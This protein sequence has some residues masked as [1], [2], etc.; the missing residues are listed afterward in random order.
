[1]SFIW[2]ITR[3][4]F[5][6]EERLYELDTL[7]VFSGWVSVSAQDIQDQVILISL[8]EFSILAREANF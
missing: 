7:A 6:W 8:G 4:I 2:D 5:R 1:M 3:E